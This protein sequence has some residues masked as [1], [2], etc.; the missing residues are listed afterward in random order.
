MWGQETKR[1][2]RQGS[3][4]QKRALALRAW[5]TASSGSTPR[6]SAEGTPKFQGG[7]SYSLCV[8]LGV[9]C[10]GGRR[11]GRRKRSWLD[12]RASS[13]SMSARKRPCHSFATAAALTRNIVTFLGRALLRSVAIRYPPL[14]CTAFSFAHSLSCSCLHASWGRR[15]SSP[16]RRP[17]NSR[18]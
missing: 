12:R 16:R 17:C 13:D 10:H 15:D 5:L 4:L 7:E 2:R 18:S 3:G 11:S 14:S 8:V 6:L 9:R 1:W